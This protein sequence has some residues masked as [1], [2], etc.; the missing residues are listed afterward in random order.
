[1]QCL[2]VIVSVVFFFESR[3]DTRFHVR[4]TRAHK[5]QALLA[6]LDAGVHRVCVEL[7]VSSMH[8]LLES[9][10]S[11]T[12]GLLFHKRSAKTIV[13]VWAQAVKDGMW[14]IYK[15]RDGHLTNDRLL[16]PE[17]QSDLSCK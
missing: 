4:H 8:R 12:I 3:Q 1:M 7:Y 5:V 6:G 9:V 2:C 10:I 11:S 17:T 15:H 16:E 14:D 13:D